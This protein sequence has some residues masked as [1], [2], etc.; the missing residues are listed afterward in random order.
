MFQ[1]SIDE[2]A[3]IALEDHNVI[4]IPLLLR[5][6]ILGIIIPRKSK[7]KTFTLSE[8]SRDVLQLNN[9][10]ELWALRVH[11]RKAMVKVTGLELTILL[12]G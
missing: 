6:L 1:T 10:S 12:P 4:Y 8:T 11:I 5:P 7:V 3:M 2:A 9:L